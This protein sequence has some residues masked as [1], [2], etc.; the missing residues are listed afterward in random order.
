MGKETV[1]QVQE[2]QS[3]RK[4]KPKDEHPETHSKQNDKNWRQKILKAT[5]ETN[6]RQGNANKIISWF[7]SRNSAGQ[8]GVEW[9]I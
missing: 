6:N 7:L 1:T 9:Y 2:A 3:P 4:D 5:K 8:K